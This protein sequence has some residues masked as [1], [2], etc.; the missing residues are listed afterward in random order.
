MLASGGNDNLVQI[1]DARSSQPR[2][3][4]TN[5]M[6]AVKVYPTNKALAWCPWQLSL[7]ATGGGKSDGMIHFWNTS[8]DTKVASINAESQVTSIQWSRTYKEFV[9]SHGFPN[10]HLSV[11]SY[12]SLN[13]IIDLPGHDARILNTTISPD[14]QTIASSASDE[15]LKFWKVFENKKKKETELDD[16][17][18][19]IKRMT[20]R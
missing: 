15:N 5:H 17:S 16:L 1:W 11:W 18:S 2:S 8:S 7:L 13:K 4:K 10:N 9:S 6:A 20:I 14:G 3:T 12:P 19:N